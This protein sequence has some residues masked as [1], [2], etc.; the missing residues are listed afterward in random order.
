MRH[1]ILFFVLVA[2]L[3]VTAACAQA[4]PTVGAP[5][6]PPVPTEAPTQAPSPTPVLSPTP[7]P[8]PAGPSLEQGQALVQS[9]CSTCHGLDRVERASK[10]EAEWRSTVQRMVAKGAQL[11]DAELEAVVAYL[12]ATYGK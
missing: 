9:Q 12:T 2:L 5:T 11:N 4:G 3:M 10:T 6:K 7:V 8:T 1:G